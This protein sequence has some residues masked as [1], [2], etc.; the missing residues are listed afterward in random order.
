MSGASIVRP[1]VSLYLGEES[2][3]RALPAG[4]THEAQAQQNGI[5]QTACRDPL[6]GSVFLNWIPILGLSM[7]VYGRYER[8]FSKMHVTRMIHPCEILGFMPMEMLFSA[9]PHLLGRT[10]KEARDT[11]EL[12]QQVVSLPHGTKRD[13]LALVKKM[14]A[15]E[16]AADGAAAEPKRGEEGRL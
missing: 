6:I 10:P 15:L 2:P 7:Q 12:A 8:A 3:N 5:Q 14:V 11:M 9:A 1:S 16:R 4:D 13:L